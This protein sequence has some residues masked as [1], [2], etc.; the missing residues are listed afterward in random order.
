[1]H[2]VITE[3]IQKEDT[4]NEDQGNR[5]HRRKKRKTMSDTKSKTLL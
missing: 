3:K 1:M 4:D 2:S 5:G